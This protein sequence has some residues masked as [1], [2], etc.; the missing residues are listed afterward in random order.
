M[1]SMS[2]EM[3]V[4]L[5]PIFPSFSCQPDEPFKF[6]FLSIAICDIMM[7]QG[8]FVFDSFSTTQS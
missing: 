6:F 8:V 4:S 5:F 2:L 1:C 3:S 7:L